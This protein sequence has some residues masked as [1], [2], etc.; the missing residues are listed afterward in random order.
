MSFGEGS[1]EYE[2]ILFDINSVLFRTGEN[3]WSSHETVLRVYVDEILFNEIINL[4]EVNKALAQKAKA[5][6]NKEFDTVI[7][8]RTNAEVIF[9]IRS[10]IEYNGNRI[11][12]LRDILNGIALQVDDDEE[13]ILP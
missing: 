1:N 7:K 9:A 2:V 4:K 13:D 6:Q 12:H 3:E 11:L 5:L 8:S 10:R